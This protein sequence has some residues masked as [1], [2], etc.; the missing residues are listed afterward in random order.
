[1]PPPTDVCMVMVDG[2]I[3]FEDLR[4]EAPEAAPGPTT[5]GDAFAAVR[6]KLRL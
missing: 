1:M 2:Q 3:V 6:A 4:M 5:I